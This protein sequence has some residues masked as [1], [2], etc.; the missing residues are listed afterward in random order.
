MSIHPLDISS[1]SPNAAADAPQLASVL[2]DGHVI[3]LPRL[4]FQ[5]LSS[6]SRFLSP[7]WLSGSRK[8]I[9][10]DQDS[11]R[12]AAGKPSDLVELAA[13]INRFTSFAAELIGTLFPRYRP[14]LSN[15]RTSFRP[16][17]AKERSSSVRK[18]DRRLH[19]DV[20]PS[21]P[22]RGERILRVFSNVNPDG[23]PRV[24]RVGEPFADMAQRF[25]PKI[26]RAMPSY[27]RVLKVLGITKGLR[28]EYDHDMLHL[29]DLAKMDTEYQQ[30]SPQEEFAFA[31]GSTWI[32]FSDQVMHAAMAGQYLLEHT[33]HMPIRAMYH[34]TSSPLAILERLQGHPLVH[35][36]Q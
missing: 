19:I 11:L 23:A 20:F 17:P 7:Q 22:N 33:V 18:D 25:L 24:W 2:E 3:Y 31:A 5:L 14:Y 35:P 4:S 26:P 16:A 1:L 9:S 6:E 32:C 36:A 10:V 27:F 12:G 29:H 34:P 13:M 21:R 15:A 8:N 28:S 30:N